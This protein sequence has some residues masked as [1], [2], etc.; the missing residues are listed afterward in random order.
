MAQ[1]QYETSYWTKSPVVL[2]SGLLLMGDS[3]ERTDGIYHAREWVGPGGVVTFGDETL[4]AQDFPEINTMLCMIDC[5]LAMFDQADFHRLYETDIEFCHLVVNA[6]VEGWGLTEMLL[7]SD[8]AEKKIE[9]FLKFCAQ[10]N[11]P[12]FTHEQIALACN[13]SRQT[14]TKTLGVMLKSNPHL[15]DHIA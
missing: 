12:R 14:V 7:V 13:L 15:Y 8:T 4:P 6:A 10:N 3:S 5:E 2:V 11:Y 9:L 1:Q